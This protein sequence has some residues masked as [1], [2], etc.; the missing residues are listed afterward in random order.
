MPG[1]TTIIAEIGENHLGNLDMAEAM[2]REAAAAGAD[3]VKFQSYRSEDLALD[4][5]EREWFDQ[6]ALSDDAHKRLMKC[7]D[8]NHVEFL[9]AP[10]TLERAKFLCEG[11]GLKKLKIASS[12]MLNRAILGYANQHVDVV[13]LSTGLS[14]LQEVKEAVDL[15]SNVKEVYILHCVT[16]YP[17]P[18]GEVNLLAIETLRNALPGTH[19]GYSDHTIGID[20]AVA[21]VALGAE[22]IE[23][24][25]TLS[26]T[27]PG[28]DHVLSATPEEMAHMVRSVRRVES[29]LGTGEKRPIAAEMEIRDMVRSRWRKD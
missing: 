28:T 1:N 16:Q 10:F 6:V 7:A 20:A 18:D 19:I 2:V 11:L 24:H 14:D 9:S 22:V 5:P 13:F 12:E 23:K 27:M 25:F 17:L 3:I 4:D 26:K 15:L 29:M 21:A 8:A